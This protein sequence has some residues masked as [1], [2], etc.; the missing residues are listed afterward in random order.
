G[1]K[2]GAGYYQYEE[3][4]RKP[5]PDPEVQAMIEAESGKRGITRR[6]ISDEEILERTIYP[7]INEGAKILEEGMA[8][9][10]GDIDIIYLYGYGFPAY[11][12]GPM[13]YADLVG[14]DRI[15]ERVRHYHEKLGAWWKPAALLERLAKEGGRFGDLK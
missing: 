13:C 3:G 11:R 5:I 4:S 14:V 9:R 1:L 10:P 6:E 15:H 7:L 8:L 12:G 2:S